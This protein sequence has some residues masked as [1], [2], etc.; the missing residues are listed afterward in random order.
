M[1]L[2]WRYLPEIFLQECSIFW[3][4]SLDESSLIVILIIHFSSSYIYDMI[5]VD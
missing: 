1:K 4:G 3:I 5:E 2:N